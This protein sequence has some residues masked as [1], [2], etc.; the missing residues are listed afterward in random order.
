MWTFS[1]GHLQLFA[2][3]A[4]R[5]VLAF[6]PLSAFTLEQGGAAL[7]EY[8]FNKKAIQH[9]FCKPAGSKAF[10][11]EKCRMEQPWRR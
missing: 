5:L 3:S 1:T 7:S 11:M 9:L 4:L 10:P 8:L 2:L 6:A